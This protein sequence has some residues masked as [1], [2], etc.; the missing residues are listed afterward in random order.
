M[1][2]AVRNDGE[3]WYS[4]DGPGDVGTDEWYS[5]EVPPAP[6]PR[7]PTVEE[8]AADAAKKRDGLL[9]VAT[10]RM[11]PLQ[12]AVDVGRATDDEVAQLMLWKGYRIDLNRIEQQEGFPAEIQ[13]PLSPDEMPPSVP[14]EAPVDTPTE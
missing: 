6:V 4:V 1:S 8:V 5:V 3:G 14:A 7:P 13:W 9:A 10:A 12:D 11:G 2:F